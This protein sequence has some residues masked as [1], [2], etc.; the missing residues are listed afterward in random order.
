MDLIGVKYLCKFYIINE[1]RLI[2][3]PTV[4]AQSLS[5]VHDRVLQ[6]QWIGFGKLHVY[7]LKAI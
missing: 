1:R 7:L 3:K 6:Q 4:N 2:R 5:R